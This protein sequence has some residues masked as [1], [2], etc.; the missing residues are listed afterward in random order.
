MIKAIASALVGPSAAITIRSL[1]ILILLSV[2]SFSQTAMAQSFTF[3][4]FEVTGNKRIESSTILSYAALTRNQ[5]ISAG[6]LNAVY[7]NILAS[8]LFEQVDLIPTGGV[9]QIA[10]V[11]LP[12][13]N[14]VAFEGNARLKT[15]VL[16]RVIMSQPRQAFNPELAEQDAGKIAQ[17]YVNAGRLAAKVTPKAIRRS[18][19]R[20]DLIF[21][22]F[23]GGLV[24]IERLSFVGNTAFSDRR[25]R[26][27]LATKQA[28]IFRS[29]VAKDTFINDRIE[30]DKQLL[31]DFYTS[32]GYVDFQITDVSSELSRERDGMFVTFIVKEGQKFTFGD[33]TVVSNIK[34]LDVDTFQKAIKSK[35]GAVYSPLPVETDISRME[36]LALLKG[37]DFLRVEPNINRNDR[38]LSLDIEYRLS[39]GPRVFVQRINI[40]GNTTTIESVIRR[41]F[42]VVEGDPFNPRGLRQSAERIKALGFFSNSTVL[43]REGSSSTQAIVDVV[44]EEKPTGTLSL[45]GSYSSTTGFAADISFKEPNFL[46]RGQRIGV[47]LSNASTN[48]KYEFSFQEPSF[49]NRD[50]IAG[51]DV[52]YAGT[53]FDTSAFNTTNLSFAPYMAFPLARNSTLRLGYS[54]AKVGVADNS[55]SASSVGDVIKAEIAKGNVVNSVFGYK[56][57]YDSRRSGL[58][59]NAGFLLQFGQD[60][61]GFGGNNSI[62]RTS[63]KGIAQTKVLAEEVTLAMTV[64]GGAL[65]YLEGSSRVSDRFTMGS[66]TMR[67]FSSQGI[68]PREKP[69]SGDVNDALGGLNFAVA[70]F[71]VGFPIGIPN[72][73]GLSGGVFYDVGSLWGLESTNSNVLYQKMTL[74]QTV[75]FSLFWETPIGPLRFNFMDV[76]KSEVHDRVE[77]FELTISSKF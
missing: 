49:L 56:Y 20:V 31:K 75:G 7:R 50:L 68:G 45:G 27:V 64:E 1:L 63:A 47:T 10:V 42:R 76:I 66:S 14:E 36:R 22:I 39:N 19:N 11:E 12:T 16:Q 74:R 44:V 54:L 32:R 9:L 35:N 28:G 46:G 55:V 69:A 51:V 21:E 34:T 57:G 37:Y 6:D 58:N 60:L 67:G 17:A 13:L 23:E 4:K 8:G 70:R 71:E 41:Q 26:G 53:D 2:A 77:S 3:S 65:R 33:V 18:D 59:P 72:E 15:E 61:G 24:E 30:Y 40:T 5:T 29:L 48:K 43:P 52:S 38:S 73:Y 25:L 62:L